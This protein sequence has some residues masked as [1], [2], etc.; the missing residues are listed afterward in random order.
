MTT[1][2]PT[3]RRPVRI[4]PDDEPMGTYPFCSERCKLVDLGRWLDGRYQIPVV[5]KD[6]SDDS[7]E[8]DV[9]PAQRPRGR[10]E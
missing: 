6:E 1:E 4:P 2:C 9:P 10:F 7:A 3:C 8:P 5:E